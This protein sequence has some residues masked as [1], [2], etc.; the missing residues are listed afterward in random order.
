M[1][2]YAMLK[3]GATGWIEKPRPV[4]GPNDAIIRPLAVAP[5]TSDVHT[6]WEGG[7]GE[8]HNMVLGHE[9][10]G[11]VDEVGSEVK[12]FKVGDRVLVAAIT[13]EWNSVNA[14]AGYPMHSGG[15][16]GGWKFSN[17][18]DGMFAEYFH[19][20]DAEGNLALM[21]EG[22]DLADA[23]MLSDMIPTGFHANELADIQYGVA[24][25]FFVLVQLV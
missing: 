16:L 6:V 20:N 9:G 25:S 4:C 11:V 18:K 3:I 15:M 17:V 22:M 12:S 1:K 21:P 10:C 19:V 23:C 24:L 2:A 13:P 14:Q 5:C 7:I 8:R